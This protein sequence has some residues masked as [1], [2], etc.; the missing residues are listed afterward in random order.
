M[1]IAGMHARSIAKFW[2]NSYDDELA[3]CNI[4]SSDFTSA[5]DIAI[6]IRSTKVWGVHLTRGKK[7]GK[8]SN[9]VFC[10]EY[11]LFRGAIAD[12]NHIF[13]GNV[14][15]RNDNLTSSIHQIRMYNPSIHLQKA[16]KKTCF[17]QLKTVSDLRVRCKALFIVRSTFRLI[18]STVCT[19]IETSPGHP[20][21]N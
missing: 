14:T 6:T 5:F 3:R 1:Y 18:L 8:G 9:R 11:P 12:E 16:T 2:K 21:N 10:V 4:P 17:K 7:Q 13:G 19:F 15:L 20:R